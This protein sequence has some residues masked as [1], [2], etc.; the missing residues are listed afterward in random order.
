MVT[1]SN[2]LAL[3]LKPH[4]KQGKRLVQGMWAK[5][6]DVCGCNTADV[7]MPRLSEAA[8]TI[9][10]MDLDESTEPLPPVQTDVA[11][12]RDEGVVMYDVK[13]QDTLVPTRLHQTTL[14]QMN[15]PS[16]PIR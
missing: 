11:E 8:L 3:L 1:P 14:H 10:F 4:G 2:T 5:P 9:D 6:T 16:S 12:T 13:P 7:L 15:N